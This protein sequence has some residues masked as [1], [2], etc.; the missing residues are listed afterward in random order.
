MTIFIN[1]KSIEF[2][3]ITLRIK[4]LVHK[5]KVVLF[6]ASRCRLTW[7]SSDHKVQQ[8]YVNRHPPFSQLSLFVNCVQVTRLCPLSGHVMSTVA[9]QRA[10]D[11]GKQ[12]VT[13]RTLSTMCQLAASCQLS[14]RA[15][16]PAVDLR[17][18]AVNTYQI[19]KTSWIPASRVF[20]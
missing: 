8:L 1:N 5:R 14:A 2:C 3:Q 20:S 7:W 12:P 18:R 13:L 11:A 10:V 6:S 17:P 4:R 15:V 9:K 19:F 16:S